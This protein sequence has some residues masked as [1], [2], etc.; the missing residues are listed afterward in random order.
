MANLA[1]QF[2]APKASGSVIHPGD[3]YLVNDQ[4]QFAPQPFPPAL[5]L[6]GRFEIYLNGKD[7]TSVASTPL[8][9]IGPV[10]PAGGWP[11]GVGYQY[12]FRRT[13]TNFYNIMT[14]VVTDVLDTARNYVVRRDRTLLYDG[15][16][17][18]SLLPGSTMPQ[19]R[20]V[21]VQLTPSGLDAIEVLHA[22]SLPRPSLDQ[23]NADFEDEIASATNELTTDTSL[24]NGLNRNADRICFGYGSVRN[25]FPSSMNSVA[26]S[27]ADA[28]AQYALYQT[29][30]DALDNGTPLSS[31]ALANPVLTA[32][33]TIGL[34]AVV[35]NACVKQLPNLDQD[36]EICFQTLQGEIVDADLLWVNSVDLELSPNSGQIDADPINLGMVTGTANVKLRDAFIRYQQ[37]GAACGVT[38]V[39]HRPNNDFDNATT[40]IN[41]RYNFAQCPNVTF[42]ADSAINRIPIGGGNFSSTPVELAMS[43]D[44]S[45]DEK[46]D[47]DQVSL[48]TVFDLAG[49]GDIVADQ[50]AC[51]L[52]NP[53]Q[54]DAET[55]VEAFYPIVEAALGT[56]WDQLDPTRHAQAMDLLL[57]PFGVGAYEPAN[58]SIDWPV[59]ETG[60]DEDFAYPGFLGADGRPDVYGLFALMDAERATPRP[61]TSVVPPTYS[62]VQQHWGNFFGAYPSTSLWTRQ[63]DGNGDPYDIAM[64]LS[65]NTLNQILGAQ[66]SSDKLRFDIE[67]P[68][69]ALPLTPQFQNA[70]MRIRVQPNLTPFLYLDPEPHPLPTT[71]A[72]PTEPGPMSLHLP[73]LQVTLAVAV[74]PQKPQWIEAAKFAVDV[75]DFDVEFRFS[76]TPGKRTLDFFGGADPQIDILPLYSKIPNCQIRVPVGHQGPPGDCLAAITEDVK[77]EIEDVVLERLH[78]MLED[79]PAPQ[80]WYPENPG[81]G[82]AGGAAVE[83]DRAAATAVHRL[84]T[85]QHAPGR[86]PAVGATEEFQTNED[87]P[88]IY[89]TRPAGQPPRRDRPYRHHI[90]YRPAHRR[91]RHRTGA[92][93]RGYGLERP[94][95]QPRRLGRNQL[96]RFCGSG[97]R[98]RRRPHALHVR[99]EL[100]HLQR[101]RRHRRTGPDHR[102]PDR[103]RDRDLPAGGAIPLRRLAVRQLS[104][105]RFRGRV[106]VR[107]RF[108][109]HGVLRLP[110][111]RVLRRLRQRPHQA[112]G[113]RRD[114][115]AGACGRAG[116][117]GDRAA[118]RRFGAGLRAAQAQVSA[119]S[120]NRASASNG[121][122][123]LEAA[124]TMKTGRFPA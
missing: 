96:R 102:P 83:S 37:G 86:R 70:I 95:D 98:L 42:S 88:E 122:V 93:H 119:S 57:E 33:A 90:V 69:V 27:Y 104:R 94:P 109:L 59:I 120:Q 34:Q 40:F 51:V 71:G 81:Q 118:R 105:G 17:Y 18:E 16:F 78:S 84:R 61:A 54:E 10:A 19:P 26:V 117:V 124:S 74:D 75:H 39:F 103:S 80:F 110:R 76:P 28:A 107:L 66:M 38:G 30:K 25:I 85:L 31:L 47:F 113:G 106:L 20:G 35:D 2:V 82:F 49:E 73:D 60:T 99:R 55:L 29:L 15:R 3:P 115:R 97:R 67:S 111:G 48:G 41:E 1:A 123:S 52:S 23:F 8:V 22:N 114:D 44:A 108:K 32:V 53:L 68:S 58:H 56:T 6:P 24:F 62:Y 87:E 100:H 14:P 45:N 101:R 92:V 91:Q 89:P 121:G 4:I 77:T 64:T 12:P 21:G 50:G 46:V 13:F 112:L 11:T 116:A 79:V 72:P 7:V 9:P 65:V 43:V 36:F 63:V 5:K